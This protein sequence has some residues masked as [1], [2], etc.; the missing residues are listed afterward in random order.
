MK[1]KLLPPIRPYYERENVVLYHGSCHDIVPRMSGID[2]ILTDPP[3]GIN[4]NIRDKSH[5]PSSYGALSNV[6]APIAGDNRPFDPYWMIHANVPCCLWGANYFSDKLPG[7]GGWFVWDK[8][9]PPW[10]SQSQAELAW[11][12]FSKGVRIFKHLWHGCNRES[13][14]HEYFHPAQ[15]P[16]LLWTWVLGGKWFPENVGTILD[17]YCGS[18]SLL[19]ACIRTKRRCIGI[20]LSE[21]YCE[22]T[23]KRCESLFLNEFGLPYSKP[24]T[25]K[26]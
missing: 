3:Y 4:L 23:A 1:L 24:Q 16:L 26:G 8:R 11:T 22:I 25:K 7:S 6:Y 18:G 5:A 19:L 12:N 10:N 17:P 13:E 21:E 20:E 2:C 9:R 15:K 14:L